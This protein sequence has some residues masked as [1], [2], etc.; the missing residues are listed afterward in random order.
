MSAVRQI[1]LGAALGVALFS[2]AH[3]QS[4][5]NATT[6]AERSVQNYL[7][8]WS[9]NQEINEASVDR[10]Y[11]PRV[12]YYG[13]GFTRAQ[14]L[15]DKERYIRQWPVRLYKEV[16]GSF[17]AKCNQDHRVC[18]ASVI[19]AWRRVSRTDAV[20]VGKARVTFDF[21]PD[22]GRLKIGRESAHILETSGM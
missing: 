16:P 13:K 3:A 22:E 5:D 20:S 6:E 11:A 8:L 17:A 12:V 9:S 19:M 21:I 1:R 2:Q 14:V 10:F 7:A 18:R 4:R 15:A